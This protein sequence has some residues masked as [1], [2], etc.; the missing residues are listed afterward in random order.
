MAKEKMEKAREQAA[1]EAVSKTDRF[2]KENGKT[3]SII[4][5]C[6]VLITLCILGYER[7][8]RAP[9][10]AEY[11]AKAFSAEN[12][13]KAGEYEK[14]FAGDEEIVGFEELIDT[15]GRAADKSAWMYAGVCQL[16]LGNYESA[17]SYLKKYNGKEPILAA[18]A[19]ACI[20]D[21]YVGLNELKEALTW[22]RKAISEADNM[23][24]A[25]YMLKAGIVC[26]EMGDNAAALA[27]YKDIKDKYPQSIEGYEI[28]KYISRIDK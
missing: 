12:A 22:Y 20:G 11:R 8:I 3:I 9:K 18:R 10:V 2:F 28:D 27:F 15:Y 14:A 5:V 4:A 24:A 25:T 1:A 17:I 26:E 6:A 7:F 13:F 21:A 19:F 23:F 16:Q